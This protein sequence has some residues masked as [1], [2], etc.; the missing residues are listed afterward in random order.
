MRAFIALFAV[1]TAVVVTAS[2][3]VAQQ[4]HSYC[5][6]SE[7]GNLDC[8]YDT[9]R[10]CVAARRGLGGTCVRNPMR[11]APVQQPPAVAVQNPHAY[12]LN[13]ESGSLDCNYDTVQQCVAARRGLGGTCV[14]NPRRFR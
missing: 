3:S 6:N 5:L 11:F 14:R 10:Q 12:C 2:A 8:N 9:V 7:S 13:S 1:V 4:P